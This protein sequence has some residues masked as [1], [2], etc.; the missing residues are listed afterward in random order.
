MGTIRLAGV[1]GCGVMGSGI[2]EVCALGGLEVRV[3]VRGGAR[4]TST[5]AGRAR[6]VRSL[7]QAVRKSRISEAERDRAL[8]LVSFTTDLT[9]LADRQVV[10]EAIPE[11]EPSKI[12]LFAELDR[13]AADPQVIF[14]SNTSSIPIIRLGKATNRAEQV[15]GTHF[16]SPVP[17]LPL[18]ELI[19]S[20]LTE[21][22]TYDRTEALI[23][24]TLGKQVIKSPDRAGF[25]VNVLL[26]PYLL[27]AMRMVES[28]FADADVIDRGMT[29]GCSHPVGPLK[30]AD[31]IGLDTIASVATA[32]YEE[33]KDQQYSP[34]PLLL[35]MVEG[36]ML[37]KKTGRGFYRHTAQTPH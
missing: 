16:F 8:G 12:A 25:V 24:E 33:H 15:I 23:T 21:P 19:G 20:L 11:H 14:A 27:S 6:L 32:L 37:G 1:V 26:V 30:L 4:A 5:A 9:D 18:V 28:G 29:L 31:L 36:G 22:D 2:A 35:R 34:P 17:A 3:A 7:D 10:F 13:I